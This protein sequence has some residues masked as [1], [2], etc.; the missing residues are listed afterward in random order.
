[1]MDGCLKI[2]ASH[3][4][5]NRVSIALSHRVYLQIW[6]LTKHVRH[7]PGRN[8]QIPP[9]GFPPARECHPPRPAVPAA[10]QGRIGSGISLRNSI[11]P[12]APRRDQVE[13]E[14]LEQ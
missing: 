14:T 3:S 6:V 1:M 7:A 13:E 9:A 10:R 8:P 2:I 12:D 4:D 5:R 11:S